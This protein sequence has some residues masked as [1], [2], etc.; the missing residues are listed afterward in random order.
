[1]PP[2][3]VRGEGRVS[4]VELEPPF[5]LVG[6]RERFVIKG[7]FYQVFPDRGEEEGEVGES[8]GLELALA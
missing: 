7:D 2:H 1:M 8:W 4:A 6:A 3:S 5:G